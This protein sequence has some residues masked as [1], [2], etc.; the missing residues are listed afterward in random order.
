VTKPGFGYFVLQYIL[1]WMRVCFVVFFVF[2]LVVL[3]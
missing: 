3:Y 2:D 1:L